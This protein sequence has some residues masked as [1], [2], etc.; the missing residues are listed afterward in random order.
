VLLVSGDLDEF[1]AEREREEGA[2]GAELLD[3]LDL[4]MDVSI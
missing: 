4:D 3:A 2:T 1:V